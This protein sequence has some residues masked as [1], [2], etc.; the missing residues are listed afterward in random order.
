MTRTELIYQIINMGEL[1]EGCVRNEM[2]NMVL[3][4]YWMGREEATK[5]V[6]DEYSSVLKGI[7]RRADKCRYHK[8]ANDVIAWSVPTNSSFGMKEAGDEDKNR[9]FYDYIY[10]SDYSGEYGGMLGSCETDLTL[11]DFTKIT[12][13]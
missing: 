11:D 8:M 1:P 13:N 6:S 12:P 7:K 3:A 9:K 10:D 4:A 2:A 5:S